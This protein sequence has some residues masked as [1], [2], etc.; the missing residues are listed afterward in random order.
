MAT[1]K[2]RQCPGCGKIEKRKSESLCREC[3]ETLKDAERLKQ[4]VNSL[5]HSKSVIDIGVTR[6]LPLPIVRGL[7]AEDQTVK[8]FRIS[9]ECLVSVFSPILESNVRHH[10]ELR[11]MCDCDHP[12]R[13][14]YSH[15]K[16]DKV[17]SAPKEF[18][19]AYD[20]FLFSLR[21]LLLQQYEQGRKSGVNLLEQLNTGKISTQ[22]FERNKK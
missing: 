5:Q 22:D 21:D 12:Q 15:I 19:D 7:D 13:G 20:N 4:L 6:H 2:E 9:L 11:P 14:M 18:I 17:I 10:F 3:A 1:Y 8:R 16:Q